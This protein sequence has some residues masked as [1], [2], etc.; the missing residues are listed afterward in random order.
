MFLSYIKKVKLVKSLHDQL[1]IQVNRPNKK[2][3]NKGKNLKKRLIKKGKKHQRRRGK[4]FCCKKGI[5]SHL[6]VSKEPA[7]PDC[8]QPDVSIIEK[9]LETF[10]F[11]QQMCQKVYET[12]CNDKIVGLET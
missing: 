2:V 10:G 8:S 1:E 6:E 12:C 4:K 5:Q 11:N 7:S 3:R 9:A